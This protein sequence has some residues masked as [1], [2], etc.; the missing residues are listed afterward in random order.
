MTTVKL[1]DPFRLASRARARHRAYHRLTAGLR[2][3]TAADAVDY[4]DVRAEAHDKLATDFITPSGRL[5][6]RSS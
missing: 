3:Q 4:E 1:K 2:P 5:G 6:R